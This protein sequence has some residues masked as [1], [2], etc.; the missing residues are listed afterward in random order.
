MPHLSIE[1]VQ[2][3]KDK[4][5]ESSSSTRPPRFGELASLRVEEDVTPQPL[6][7]LIE[8]HRACHSCQPT[9]SG[10][11]GGDLPKVSAYILA[12]DLRVK[13][14]PICDDAN[15]TLP[16]SGETRSLG[17]GLIS[18]E[19]NRRQDLMRGERT[20]DARDD[21]VDFLNRVLEL[22]VGITR[23]Q[24]EFEDESVDLVDDESAR[25]SISCD[26]YSVEMS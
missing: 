4:V 1:L 11:R 13:H 16:F 26:L 12:N 10:M 22:D 3:L 6:S 9:V 7:E 2:R 5:L 15:D 23:W 20:R 24:T 19:W 21:S 25:D 17:S 8:V 18:L 14:H